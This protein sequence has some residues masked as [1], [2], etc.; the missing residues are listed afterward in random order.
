MRPI[1]TA[2]LAIAAIIAW[3]WWQAE[4]AEVRRESGHQR[5]RR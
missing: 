2:A 1:L 3:Y 5:R 4:R